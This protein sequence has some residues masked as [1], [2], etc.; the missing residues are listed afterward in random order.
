[1]LEALLAQGLRS[2]DALRAGRAECVH[3]EADVRLAGAAVVDGHRPAGRDGVRE[4]R[5]IDPRVELRALG[6]ARHRVA[7]A[8]RDL[9]LGAGCRSLQRAFT[10]RDRVDGHGQLGRAAC[11]SVALRAL[12]TV[13]AVQA[14]RPLSARWARLT[15]MTV[16]A[17]SPILAVESGRV[18]S[19]GRVW[20]TVMAVL[21]VRAR[22]TLKARRALPTRRA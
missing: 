17:G 10:G 6:T 8:G 21:T 1:M 12:R 14:G 13:A 9:T 18:L 7:T 11:S 15:V 5:R 19:I 16:R 3:R 20:E 22:V 4:H 2:L